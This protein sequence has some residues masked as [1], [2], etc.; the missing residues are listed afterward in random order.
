MKAKTLVLRVTRDQIQSA[1]ALIELSGGE[2]KV[3]PEIVKIAHAP[4]LTPA[5]I[6]RLEAS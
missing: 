2:D 1:R 4:T 5:E 3:D 6:R